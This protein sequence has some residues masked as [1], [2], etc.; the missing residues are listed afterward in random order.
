MLC[1]ANIE[2]SGWRTISSFISKCAFLL[3]DVIL[4]KILGTN[5]KLC[6]K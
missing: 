4:P 3:F 1:N 5:L 6:P 2:E